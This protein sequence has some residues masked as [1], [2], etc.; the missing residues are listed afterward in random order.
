MSLSADAV[1]DELVPRV[2]GWRNVPVRPELSCSIRGRDAG[3]ETFLLS[4][5]TRF[6]APVA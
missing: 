6:E 1:N 5:A 2:P 4:D 3:L